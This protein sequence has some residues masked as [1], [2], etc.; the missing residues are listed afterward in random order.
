MRFL[1]G[2]GES[3]LFAD[4]FCFQDISHEK[5]MH[6]DADFGT[7]EHMDAVFALCGQS[8]F[9]R[10]KGVRVKMGRWS[11]WLNSFRS[12]RGE[13]MVMLLVLAYVG[14]VRGWWTS[15]LDLPFVSSKYKFKLDVETDD[16]VVVADAHAVPAQPAG[17]VTLPGASSSSGA[18]ASASAVAAA[19]SSGSGSGSGAPVAQP[20]PN[21]GKSGFSLAGVAQA[22]A[23]PKQASS[24]SVKLSNECLSAVRKG[25]ANTLHFAALVLSNKFGNQAAEMVD[26]GTLAFAEMFGK[27]KTT[28]KTRVGA[29]HWHQDLA[30]GGVLNTISDA[31]A[32]M[33]NPEI[34]DRVDFLPSEEF[35][36]QSAEAI[37]QDNIIS[38]VWFDLVVSLSWRYATSTM[39]YSAVYPMKFILLIMAGEEKKKELLA[40]FKADWELLCRMERMALDDQWVAGFLRSLRWPQEQF[41]REIMVQLAEESFCVVTDEVH[42]R[43]IGLAYAFKGTNIVEGLHNKYRFAEGASSNGSFGRTARWHRSSTSR[44]LTEYDCKAI[45]VTDEARALRAPAVVAKDFKPAIAEFSMDAQEFQTFDEP[46]AFHRFSPAALKLRGVLWQSATALDGNVPKMKRSWLSLLVSPGYMVHVPGEAAF[47]AT[48]STRTN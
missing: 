7:P 11:S 9:M 10:L 2:C 15:A 29:L 35:E 25:C 36:V 22:S 46:T 43:V 14:V 45:A 34:V 5:G 21:V 28:C 33:G 1:A 26:A 18:A 40:E 30:A 16:C 48:Q 20:V 41:V 47:D 44:L 38:Q 42:A 4:P 23:A 32:N 37:A 27:G 8:K 31:F 39:T 13:K 17:P 6:L 24:R 12:L 3:R 19:P